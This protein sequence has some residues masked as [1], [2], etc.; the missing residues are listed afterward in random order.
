M[1]EGDLRVVID[2]GL[3]LHTNVHE[4]SLKGETR[5]S[6]AMME[7]RSWRRRGRCDEPGREAMHLLPSQWSKSEKEKSVGE[8][9]VPWAI[10]CLLFISWWLFKIDLSISTTTSCANTYYMVA[11]F[12]LIFFGDLLLRVLL[13]LQKEGMI[14]G[15]NRRKSKNLTDSRSVNFT[16]KRGGWG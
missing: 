11:H 9:S 3:C 1:N 8:G 7:G 13:F 15:W 5:M 16:G 10:H 2:Y 12:N 4:S 6:A 14:G